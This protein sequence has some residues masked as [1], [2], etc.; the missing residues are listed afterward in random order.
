MPFVEQG[1]AWTDNFVYVIHDGHRAMVIDPTDAQLVEK[2]LHQ[3]SLS[4]S[5]ILLTHHHPD[6]VHGI[7]ELL[8]NHGNLPVYCSA[9]DRPRIPQANHFLQP[10]DSLILLQEKV[11]VL[12][13]RGHT[14]GQ[15][16]YWWPKDRYLFSGDCIFGL[17]CGRLFEGSP[18]DLY[19]SLQRI[20]NLP[21]ESLIFCSH[22]Y[23]LDNARFQE[24]FEYR[25]GFTDYHQSLIKQRSQQKF[26]V[27]LRLAEQCQW[28]LFLR[29]D[30]NA[31]AQ[32]LGISDLS[33]SDR[34]G[35]LR[36]LKDK[37]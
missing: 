7:D 21:R 25:P 23:T 1:L 22:E 16:G 29:W 2:V 4:L 24:A 8:N 34:I 3:H 36:K 37:F 28:N 14:L 17:G 26:T 10:G 5:A 19:E 15:I 20:R 13:L 9:Y 27:P 32:H 35:Y 30:D 12:D 31:L 18:Q 11:E 33:A 6:H